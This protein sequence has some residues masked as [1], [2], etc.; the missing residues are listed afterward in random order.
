MEAEIFCLDRDLPAA[1]M[2]RELL[3]TQVDPSITLT[4]HNVEEG[5]SSRRD[6]AGATL[7]AAPA[8]DHPAQQRDIAVRHRHG[9]VPEPDLHAHLLADEHRG[10]LGGGGRHLGLL[11]GLPGVAQHP[12]PADAAAG[13]GAVLPG[14]G[15]AQPHGDG[16]RGPG[17]PADPDRND[18][19]RCERRV[20]PRRPRG[21][22]PRSRCRR[23]RGDRTLA[24]AGRGNT[25]RGHGVHGGAP[26]G[27]PR[28]IRAVRRARRRADAFR[29]GP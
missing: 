7:Y 11:R 21:G 10:R 1:G 27:H 14:P 2:L 12:L 18:A 23:E 9:L 8:G 25:A 29:S 16:P 22:L 13:N 24:A 17:C 28:R 15:L 4:V 19:A 3:S 6:P 20:G 5:D 26:R